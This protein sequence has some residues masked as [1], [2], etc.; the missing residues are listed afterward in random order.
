MKQFEKSKADSFD[1]FVNI[2]DI[3]FLSASLNL[4]L[5]FGIHVKV[6]LEVWF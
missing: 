1:H 6:K 3:P 4:E 5:F 2:S